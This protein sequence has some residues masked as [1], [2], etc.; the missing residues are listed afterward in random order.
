MRRERMGRMQAAMR[1]QGLDA[2][3]LLGNTN[4]VYATGAIWPL[5]DS[6]RANFEQPVAVVLV[7]DEWPHLFSPMREDEQFLADLPPDHLHGPV[8]LDFD[9]GVELF[10]SQLEGLLSANAVVAMDEWTNALCREQSILFAKGPPVDGGRVISQA[11][12]TKTM[13][14]LSCMREAL[15]ITECAIADVQASIAP[16]VRQTDLT[17]TFLRTIFE[18]GADANILDPIWQVMP[19]RMADGPWTTTGDL[20]CPLLSTERELAE[21]DVLW[22][23]T[24]ISYGGFH[25]DFGRTWIVGREP[26][27][28]QRA[29]FERWRAIRDAVLG[30]T[31]GR[32]NRVGSDGGGDRRCWRRQALDAPLLPRAR[33]WHRQRRDAL[34]GER[35]RRG[36]RRLAGPCGWNGPRDRA[37]RLGR[38][39]RGL[40]LRRGTPH[41]GGRLGAHDRLLLR[42]LLSISVTATEVLPDDVALRHSRRARVLAEMESEGIDLL[43]LGREGNARYVSGAPRLWTAGSRAFGPG[44]VLERATG[45]VYLLSTWDEGIPDDIPHENL[46][47]ISFNAGNFVKALRRIEGAATARTVATDS[48]TGSSANLLPKAFPAAELVDGEPMLRRVRRIKAPEEVEAIRSSVRIA[49]RALHEAEAALAPGITERQLTGVFM[50]AMASAGVTTP[51]TQDVAWTTS[52]RHPWQRA[53]RDVPLAEVTWWPSTPVSSLAAMPE[54]S[55]GPTRWGVTPLVDPE[56]SERWSELWDRLLAACQPGAPLSSLLAAYDTAGLPAP[57][58]PVARGLGLGFDLP[59]VTHALP[60]EAAGQTVEAG[61]VLVLTAYL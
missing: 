55:A 28:R 33:S 13:D 6:G 44:C 1:D 50:Q 43:V 20:A 38:R 46:Y 45:S 5:A 17:A 14:E 42:S 54:S 30:V 27:T 53:N 56:L 51:S 24:G 37:D 59:L 11:K 7:D 57:P 18:A 52:R 15:R 19:E 8:Y 10:A 12:A 58:M 61:M 48:L 41:H 21:G 26:N 23:D 40:P 25:S 3:V 22:V 2:L 4:V 47:G 32:S 60:G 35:H 9:E 39:C 31:T 36:V 29:Q 16:G 49:E 34:C